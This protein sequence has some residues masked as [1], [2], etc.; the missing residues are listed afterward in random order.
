ML[1]SDSRRADP[2]VVQIDAA[3][4]DD[5]DH[6]LATGLVAVNFHAAFLPGVDHLFLTKPLTGEHD[7]IMRRLVEVKDVLKAEFNVFMGAAKGGVT[8]VD[9]RCKVS[10]QDWAI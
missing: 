9:G 3:L 10:L 7:A 1:G 6:V 8:V 5:V 2:V 4:K